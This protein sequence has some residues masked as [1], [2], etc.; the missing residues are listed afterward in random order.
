M[1]ETVM[2]ILFR[3]EAGKNSFQPFSATPGGSSFNSIVSIGRAGM[4]CAFIGYT[5]DDSIG[6][7]TLDFLR[8]NNVRTD[9]FLLYNGMKSSLALAFLDKKGDAE[10]S[11]Y[12]DVPHTQ[13]N[14]PL[15]D[16]NA[17]D[18]L[19]FGSYY[20]ICAG[21]RKHVEGVVLRAHE[22]GAT[23]YYDINFR[24]SHKEELEALLPAIRWNMEHSD[25]VRG[26]ADDFDIMC[27]T[28]D[29]GHI[30]N[31]FILPYCNSFIYTAGAGHVVI[32]SDGSRFDFNADTIPVE[33]I[34]ST[35]GAGDN[36]NAGFLCEFMRSGLNNGNI[37][38]LTASH[39]SDLVRTAIHFA[40]AVCQSP[41]NN[42][43]TGFK[44]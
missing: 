3:E 41:E 12:K 20:A 25:I 31:N 43:P 18:A 42:I 13:D 28:R 9:Y 27:G 33:K 6:H 23:V 2:D 22:A 30:Y 5:G 24:R 21:M 44:Y 4:K 38:Q 36:F 32:F 34:V 14:W 15:P 39:W 29:A 8:H 16:F 40:S 11:F 26:S 17:S 35:V 7:Q 10:Y 1:G 19:L 37:R